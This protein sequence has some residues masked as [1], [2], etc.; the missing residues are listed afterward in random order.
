L[1]GRRQT[2][3][4]NDLH[5]IRLWEKKMIKKALITA[6]TGMII[7][8]G[9]AGSAVADPDGSQHLRGLGGRVFLVE[10]HDLFEDVY[11]DNCYTFYA[12]GTWD[13]PQFPA[14]GSWNQ[15]S[16]GAKTSYTGEALAEDFNLGSEE[17]PFIVDLLLEQVGK[18]TPAHG[19]G[20]LQLTAFSQAIFVD[21]MGG[22]DLVVGEFVSVGYEVEECP[23]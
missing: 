21:F 19:E 6:I 16:N 18:V 23:L 2:K 13:D 3:N 7:S 17:E 11:F 4:Y 12:D 20:N 8:F 1:D 14:L 10:V 9:I 22:G 5:K 15:D